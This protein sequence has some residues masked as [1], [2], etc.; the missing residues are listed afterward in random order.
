MK[1]I[2]PK[3]TSRKRK[4]IKL[5]GINILSCIR[6]LCCVVPGYKLSFKKS[7]RGKYLYNTHKIYN[8]E[9]NQLHSSGCDWHWLPSTALSST[10]CPPPGG[11]WGWGWWGWGWWYFPQ[12]PGPPVSINQV[13]GAQTCPRPIWWLQ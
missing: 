7:S 12:Q 1:F 4:T 2:K 6:I 13:D 8:L 10:C 5:G 11:G 9:T 3:L